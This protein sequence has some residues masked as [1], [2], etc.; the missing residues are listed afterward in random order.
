MCK[1]FEEVDLMIVLSKRKKMVYSFQTLCDFVAA[2]REARGKGSI[3]LKEEKARAI[4]KMLK[5]M[6]S[7]DG[8]LDFLATL[9]PVHHP[10]KYMPIGLTTLSYTLRTILEAR[11]GGRGRLVSVAKGENPFDW[12][13]SA[14]AL[15]T[16]RGAGVD[17]IQRGIRMLYKTVGA[18]KCENLACVLEA[19]TPEQGRLFCEILG[20]SL[21][22]GFG[23][24][25]FLESFEDKGVVKTWIMT[26]NLERV[27][28][29][30]VTGNVGEMTVGYYVS[31][32]LARQKPFENA[33]EAFEFMSGSQKKRRREAGGSGAY[34]AQ[35]KIDGYRI[36]LHKSASK[37]R[38]WYYSRHNLDLGDG[39]FFKVLND[40]VERAIGADVDCILDGEVIA[41]DK[42]TCEFVPCSEMSTFIWMKDPNIRLAYFVFDVLYYNGMQ[43]M[44][45]SYEKRLGVLRAAIPA[46]L[47]FVECGDG[48]T[49]IPMFEGSQWGGAALA[50]RVGS[51]EECEAYFRETIERDLEG[52][53]LKDL[54]SAWEPYGRSNNHLKIKPKPRSYDLFI[55]G[56]NMNRMQMV[57]A[58][59]LAYR[60][61]DDQYYTLCMCGTGLTYRAKQVLT[62]VIA[63]SATWSTKGGRD[64]PGWL[65]VYGQERPHMFLQQ[66]MS[67]R[68]TAHKMTNSK[69]YAG[70]KTLR[71]P[72]IREIPGIGFNKDAGNTVV[73]GGGDEIIPIEVGFVQKESDVLVG[74]RIWIVNTGDDALM[75]ELYRNVLRM[76]GEYVLDPLG[77]EKLDLIIVP[78]GKVND[79]ADLNI[80]SRLAD[81]PRVNANW[82]RKT[83]L[84]NQIMKYDEF[85]A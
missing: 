9:F 15:C 71:F 12:I 48:H 51:A 50:K 85:L 13:A 11:G 31:S 46:A 24:K 82:I 39:Y 5:G 77:E 2:C 65:H 43:C 17:M 52:V 7:A 69:V 70:G 14:D 76:G 83:Y 1:K 84:W 25:H 64:V 36:Q 3:K 42:R 45:M 35:L 56:A 6:S 37:R 60:C 30:I 55:V 23:V 66:P 34:I 40:A 63:E 61:D 74:M 54:G 59:L 57:S 4:G 29:A 62:V 73:Y 28:R 22:F 16:G 67:C 80:M 21:S 33:L 8:V 75:S 19:C 10:E 58:V 68:V 32:M 78:N 79:E 41:F 53:M 72:V 47:G 38:V 18:A 27:A 20:C 49:V 44:S 26:N 81:V